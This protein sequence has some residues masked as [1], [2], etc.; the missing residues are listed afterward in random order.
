MWMTV[1]KKTESHSDVINCFKELPSYKTNIEKPK[2]K[3]LNNIDLR[4]ELP[5]YEELSLLKTDKVFRGYAMT[6]KVQLVDKK[7]LYHN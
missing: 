4:S 7:I 2:I 6:Y 3:C 5:Y 1:Q